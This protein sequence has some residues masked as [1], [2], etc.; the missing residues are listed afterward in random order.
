MY[1]LRKRTYVEYMSPHVVIFPYIIVKVLKRKKKT[2]FVFYV[3]RLS[4]YTLTPEYQHKKHHDNRIDVD[5][6]KIDSGIMRKRLNREEYL[7]KKKHKGKLTTFS[8]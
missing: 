2:F 4:K 3:M 5:T 6:I 7:Q 1:T 8:L